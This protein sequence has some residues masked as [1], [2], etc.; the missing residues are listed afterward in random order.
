[1][2]VE[3]AGSRG[4]GGEWGH[5]AVP[6]SP[7]AA[8]TC[9]SEAMRSGPNH[10]VVST[11]A[12]VALA[13]LPS[14]GRG[15]T[16]GH[17]RGVRNG[18]GTGVAQGPSLLLH[19]GPM[20]PEGLPPRPRV[21]SRPHPGHPVL[22]LQPAKQLHQRPGSGSADGGPLHQPDAPQPQVSPALPSVPWL[23]V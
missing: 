11:L 18:E 22:C 14:A 15:W 8:D 4:H 7:G 3:G 16:A 23:G 6:L 1:M 21:L 17:G 5:L 20:T 13:H 19:S 10:G 12:L 2:A 9:P